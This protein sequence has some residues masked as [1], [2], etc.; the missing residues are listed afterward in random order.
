M[1]TEEQN[2][3]LTR[4][5]AGTPMG[6]LLRRYWQPIAALDEL[7]RSAVKAVRLCGEDLVAYRDLGGRYGLLERHCS[8]RG[9]DLANGFVEEHGLRCSYHG[10]RYAETGGC[11]EQ[12][13]EE[14]YNAESRLRDRIRHKAYPVAAKAGLLWAYLGPEPAPLL[15]DWEPFSWPHGFVQ[16]VFADV[17]CNWLQCQ[18]NSIDPVHFEWLHANWGR[19]LRQDDGP[20]APA[21]LKLDFEEF[22]HGLVYRRVREDTDE[23]HPLWTVGRTCLWPN[24]FFLGDHFEW[25]VPVD[26]ENTLAVTWAYWRVPRERE[27]YVQGAIPSWRSPTVDP[28]TG[29]WI[30]SHVINQDIIAWAGQGRIADRTREN[31]GASDRGVWMLRK[32]LFADLERI[33]RGEDP[34]ALVRDPARNR[35]IALP[36]A[37]RKA[38]VDGLTME[39]CLRHPVV[40]QH[41]RHFPFHAGQPEAVK[42]AYEAA[43]GVTM[44]DREIVDV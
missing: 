23:T 44:L 4:V 19:R 28:A 42:R 15:P 14:R 29:K 26:D 25:R 22:E 24:A 20:P 13:F 40:G 27:P 35:C 32:R 18:E 11:L 8:H 41:M 1:L 36:V 2:R 10:W 34:S 39:E 38:L 43:M 37:M 5:G 16:I 17:P 6:A 31:L 9:A 3:T 7:D 21:H 12:P 33:A 30:A